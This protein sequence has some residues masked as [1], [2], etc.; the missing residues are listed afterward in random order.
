[1]KNGRK[2]WEWRRM[3]LEGRRMELEGRRWGWK[4][5]GWGVVLFWLV[6]LVGCGGKAET[7]NGSYTVTERTFA[8]TEESSIKEDFEYF[9]LELKP[10][11]DTLALAKICSMIYD[12]DT[13]YLYLNMPRDTE[14][15]AYRIKQ[16]RM[17]DIVYMPELVEIDGYYQKYVLY[18]GAVSPDRKYVITE[19][20]YVNELDLTDR[21]MYYQ[22]QICY[23][24]TEEDAFR[25]RI[26]YQNQVVLQ[27][28]L[29]ECIYQFNKENGTFRDLWYKVTDNYEK[30]DEDKRSFYYFA[31]N[32]FDKERETA[33]TPE[34][35]LQV[36]VAYDE[37]HY[38]YQGKE[39]DGIY[40]I[41]PEVS[42]Q[43]EAITPDEVTVTARESKRSNGFFYQYQTINRLAD[44]D[45]TQNV[46]EEKNAVLQMA[47]D[48]Y[49][50]AILFGRKEGYRYAMNDTWFS[51]DYEYTGIEEFRTIR[52]T[53]L[54]EGH[55]YT[56]N[57]DSLIGEKIVTLPE[58]VPENQNT[59]E[60]DLKKWLVRIGAV[61]GLVLVWKLRKGIGFFIGIIG[62][63][64]KREKR[65]GSRT[66]KKEGLE[67]EKKKGLEVNRKRN[68]KAGGEEHPIDRERNLEA[69]REEILETDREGDLE[70][71][72][73]ESF[74]M[75]KG[76]D[77]EV[78]REGS[79]ETDREED[80]G[81]D[82]LF[83]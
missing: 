23:M 24:E 45:F 27:G 7:E 10:G 6:F 30:L 20:E 59:W 46:S 11:Y 54:L 13:F 33:F 35:I 1:M 22:N 14:Q 47:A 77:F 28:K 81:G 40:R 2:W 72:R 65:R 9:G 63:V 31:F 56:V 38:A 53:Y 52:V 71:D 69:D 25:F 3:E 5:L 83:K 4:R 34:D 43:E 74:K 32:C 50:W 82:S 15:E 67:E 73:E 39:K 70:T 8:I 19:M 76:E 42:H 66:E 80:S 64:L 51:H 16:M 60:Q 79:F 49:D 18:H 62:K 57:T 55:T 21:Y 37:L 68:L 12:G 61:L 58:I 26:E 29:F 44:A 17:N 78:N 36:D 41:E 48:A 75:D